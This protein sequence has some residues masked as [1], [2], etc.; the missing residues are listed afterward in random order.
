[1]RDV[2]KGN[3]RVIATTRPYGYSQE[4]DPVHYLHLNLQKLSSEKA[5]FYAGRWIEVREPTPREAVTILLVIIRARG[6]PPKQREELFERYTDIIYQREQKKRPELLRTEPDVIYGLHKYLAYTLHKRTGKDNTAALMDVSE[7][8]ERVKEYL[9]HSN[10]L[11]NE[12][13]LETKANQIIREASQR[14]VLIESPIEGKVGFGLTTT[15]EFFA[16]AHLVDTAKDTK[17]RDLRFKA[18]AKSPH[19]RNVALFFAGRVGRTRPGEAPSM[20][21]VCREIDTEGVD[22]F[23]KRGAE[24]VMGMVDDRVLREPHNEIG[25]IQYGLTLLD[26]GYIRGESDEL[27]NKL[28]S[29]PDEYKERII[30][31]W[32]E[33]RLNNVIPENLMLHAEIYQ[34][35]FS[36]SEPLH[37]AIKRVSEFDSKDVK[38]WALSQAIKNK[39]V[40]PWVMELLEELSDIVPTERIAGTLAY[41]WPNFRFYLNF[42]LSSKARTA[43]ALALLEGIDR[44][45]SPFEP[46]SSKAMAELSMIKP[47]GKRKE[48]SLLLWAVSQL[49]MLSR[50]SVLAGRYRREWP[51]QF[52]LPGITNPNVKAM[53]NKNRS[54]IED[55]CET[56][57][58]ENEPFIKSL[59]AVFQF[60][61]A[62]HNP[63]KY[64]A[65]SKQLQ[66]EEKSA[67]PPI[68][69][70][71][72]ILRLPPDGEEEDMYSYHDDLYTLYNHY[73][74]EEQYKGDIEELNELIN[75][76]SKSIRTHPYKL[77]VWINS[78]CDPAVEKFLDSEILNALK[79]WLQERGLTEKALGLYLWSMGM[80]SD[81]ELCEVALEI[82]EKQLAEGQK[83]LKVDDM[84]AGYGWH[85]SKTAQELMISN[86]LKRIFEDVLADYSTLIDP[87]HRYLEMLYWSALGAG[88]A[89]EKH[90]VELYEIIHNEPDFSSMP[91]FAER[92]ESAW[93]T[94]VNMLQSDNQEVAHL[95]A[96][97]LLGISRIL[98][99]RDGQKGI[100]KEAWVGD[101]YW[102]FAQ[103]KGDVWRP[104]YIEGMAQCR[105]KW[106]ENG[107]KWLK[108]IKEANTEKL[109]T[110]WRRVLEEAD[111]CN[112]K[113]RDA[114]F[115]SLLHI[116]ESGDAF[117]KP[118]RLA[119]L[120]RLDEMV[121]LVE[122][123]GLDEELLNLPL[124]RRTGTSFS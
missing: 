70:V 58:D 30:C 53:I 60:L 77:L 111:Y 52:D 41:R 89:E 71:Q 36:M 51:I 10:P 100:I 106:A 86:R 72:S 49:S 68:R 59:I 24:L 11:L 119:A 44:Y 91:W 64:I 109:Q 43:V 45:E 34:K 46:L 104:R 48:N 115:D 22:K 80:I 95:A 75:K 17:E 74:S 5:D 38:L 3:L 63:E 66:R 19:W 114:L 69:I 83:R 25:A 117:A 2:L 96:I 123:V 18:I 31:P 87:H 67:F 102:A 27:L 54:I 99:L 124:S 28:K 110:A 57:S 37:N 62:P 79:V 90:M 92:S 113:D 7:F 112:A 61:I 85:E 47:E 9:N 21:D 35:L 120:R 116:L 118:I 1:V 15:R 40:E 107:Q 78:A 94:L 23:L 88:V 103:D 73:K 122:P 20:I 108:A 8:R 26:S 16:A 32:M 121:S 55:F 12:G 39:I 82:I 4:F 105:L 50:L 65:I 14:L 93:P 56:F 29:L 42:S 33:K 84:I 81:L 13:E 76:N 98:Y 101:K 6:T 97:T